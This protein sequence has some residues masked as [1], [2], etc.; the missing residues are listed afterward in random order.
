MSGT[1]HF[2]D[3]MIAQFDCALTMERRESFVVAGT[4]GFSKCLTPSCRVPRCG[5]HRTARAEVPVVHQINGVDEYQLMVEHFAD[6]VLNQR[7]LRYGPD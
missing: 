4:D 3:D 7:P 5:H 1:L 2:G 6:A